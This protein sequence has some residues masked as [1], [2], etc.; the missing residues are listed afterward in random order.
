MSSSYKMPGT[1]LVGCVVLTLNTAAHGSLVFYTGFNEGTGSPGGTYLGSNVTG[2][3]ANGAS[4]NS[5]TNPFTNGGHSMYFPAPNSTPG[6]VDFITPS[7]N[8]VDFSSGTVAVWINMEAFASASG[9]NRIFTT[10]TSG[11]SDA[12]DFY[13]YGLNHGSRAG[14]IEFHAGSGAPTGTQYNTG[15]A[16]FDNDMLNQWYFLAV[17]WDSN[18]DRMDFYL[19]DSTGDLNLIHTIDAD[20]NVNPQAHG[21][22]IRIGAG[23]FSNNIYRGLIDEFYLYNHALTMSELRALMTVPEPASATVLCL[24]GLLLMR[25]RRA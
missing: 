13:I 11:Q 9:G 17:T 20:V 22:S 19:G 18:A 10:R 3:M 8:D 5:Q 24:G 1:L 14:Y 15:K 25:R 7:L 21:P 4:Y 2:T 12:F 23:Q 16:V 6:G